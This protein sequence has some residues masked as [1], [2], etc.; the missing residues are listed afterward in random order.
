MKQGVVFTADILRSALDVAP[1]EPSE[2]EGFEE[3]RVWLG[4]VYGITPSGKYY[5]PI[6]CGNVAGDCP[7]CAGEGARE[8]RTGRRV[9]KRALARDRRIRKA[10]IKR[11]GWAYLWPQAVKERTAKLQ[12]R[13]STTCRACDGLG[14][15]S[16]A[17]DARWNEAL[18]TM[19]ES[20]GA[21]ID[22]GEGG[23]DYFV[24][25]TR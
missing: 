24:V 14:S 16:A 10:A 25:E 12:Q 11:F 3:R 5:A 20:I 6:A 1:W 22:H 9:R 4:T 21:F 19:A 15:I 18:E 17:R 13:A 23:E 7:V 2:E 8:P